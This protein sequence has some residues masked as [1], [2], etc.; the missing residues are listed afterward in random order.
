MDEDEGMRAFNAAWGRKKGDIAALPPDATMRQR[1]RN[2]PSANSRPA[3]PVRG[4]PPRWELLH[5]VR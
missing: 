5:V 3:N 4:R 1:Q 2:V